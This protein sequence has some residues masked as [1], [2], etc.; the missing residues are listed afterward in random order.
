MVSFIYLNGAIVGLKV[1]HCKGQLFQ[2][3]N[4]E[5]CVNDVSSRKK[6]LRK[7]SEHTSHRHWTAYVL[8]VC[9]KSS[10]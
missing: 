2:E 1:S 6:C 3:G 5:W 10:M 8:C 9:D 4:V 7:L